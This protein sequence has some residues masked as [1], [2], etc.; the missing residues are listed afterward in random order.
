M[1]RASAAATAFVV[2]GGHSRRMGRDKALLAWGEGT[3][4]DHALARLRRVSEDVRIL[5]GR[6]PRYDDR[7]APLVPDAFAGSGAL[8][9]VASGLR[10]V[11][12]PLGLFLAVDLPHV[13]EEVL[14]HL[15]ALARDA[16]AV[17]PFSEAGPE[18][19]C[20]VYAR[21]C[22]GPIEAAIGRGELKMTSFWGEVRVRRVLPP[23]LRAFGDPARLFANLNAPEDYARAK[24]T[25]PT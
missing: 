23:E 4:L 24:G 1:P 7:G 3:L 9:G 14:R 18:P 19:L 10:A 5:C 8:V 6:Q 15:L 12:R 17:V 22:L 16:D 2:A 20:A 11:E 25:E 21:A 13:T